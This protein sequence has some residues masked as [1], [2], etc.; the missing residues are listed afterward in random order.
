MPLRKYNDASDIMYFN[1][2]DVEHKTDKETP[3]ADFVNAFFHRR[4]FPPESCS[5]TSPSGRAVVIKLDTDQ[6]LGDICKI[7]R[8]FRRL[9]INPGFLF[10]N[11]DY[12]TKIDCDGNLRYKDTSLSQIY[13][14]Y[15]DRQHDLCMDKLGYG[16]IEYAPSMAYLFAYKGYTYEKFR[17]LHFDNSRKSNHV[18]DPICKN[19]KKVYRAFL[20]IMKN[21]DAREYLIALHYNRELRYYAEHLDKEIEIDSI[22]NEFITRNTAVLIR[23]LWTDTNKF[24]IACEHLLKREDLGNCA[25]SMLIYCLSH[26]PVRLH[27]AVHRPPPPLRG[28]GGRCPGEPP[29]PRRGSKDGIPDGVYAGLKRVIR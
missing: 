26:L 22:L 3:F 15:I 29:E 9:T 5:I 8:S 10:D 18:L 12:L 1:P 20:F 27:R 2:V 25:Q 13:N 23:K 14:Y 24:V 17:D 21:K 28:N 7:V 4:G 16:F 6:T 11:Y 19:S